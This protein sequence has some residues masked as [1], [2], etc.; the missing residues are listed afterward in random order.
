MLSRGRTPFLGPDPK[1]AAAPPTPCAR[2]PK[3]RQHPVPPPLVRLVRLDGFHYAG[4]LIALPGDSERPDTVVALADEAIHANGFDGFRDHVDVRRESL[5]AQLEIHRRV[6]TPE[7]KVGII[8]GPCAAGRRREASKWRTGQ[9]V[10][11]PWPHV[12]GVGGG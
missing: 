3:G 9:P 5:E 1:P 2:N 7:A 10:A 8:P 11:Q 6:A 12:E 4:A